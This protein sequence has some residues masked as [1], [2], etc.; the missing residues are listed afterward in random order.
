MVSWLSFQIKA[1]EQNH[2][3]FIF[4]LTPSNQI[5]YLT[6]LNEQN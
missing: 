4:I 6:F 3:F 1:Q 2:F 5:T